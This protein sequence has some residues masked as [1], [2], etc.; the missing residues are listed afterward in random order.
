ML[1]STVNEHDDVDIV[2]NRFMKKLEG[3]IAISFREKKEL[4]LKLT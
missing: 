2:V 1:S 4:N 3:C